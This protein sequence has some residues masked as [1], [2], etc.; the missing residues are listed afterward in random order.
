MFGNVDAKW[1]QHVIWMP[2]V[3]IDGPLSTSGVTKPF[4]VSGIG[5]C[6][7]KTVKTARHMLLRR[8]EVNIRYDMYEHI[9]VRA[10]RRIA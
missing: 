1:Y 4:C 2:F 7:D 5:P 8:H 6:M 9:V 3:G 10:H